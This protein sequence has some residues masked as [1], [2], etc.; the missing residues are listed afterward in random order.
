ME[1]HGE[2]GHHMPRPEVCV[3]ILT[4][5]LFERRLF[6][7]ERPEGQNASTATRP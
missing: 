4:S 2:K 1:A 5:R 7:A 3:K 6:W